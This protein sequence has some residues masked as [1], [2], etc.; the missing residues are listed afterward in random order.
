MTIALLG[1]TTPVTAGAARPKQFKEVHR[2]SR[3]TYYAPKGRSVDV[4]R[5]EAFLDRLAALFGA[6]PDGWRVQYYLHD[7]A[8][9]YSEMG[10]SAVGVT[11]LD[12]L[13]IDSVRA[14]HPHELVHAMAARLGRPP[15]LFVE[16]LAVALTSE[17]RWRG[18]GL[19][20]MAVAALGAS[21]SPRPFLDSFT[22][23][24][25]DAAYAVAGSLVAYLLDRYGIEPLV[26]FLQ[27]CGFDARRYEA[28]FKSA[29]GRTVARATLEW[30]RSLHDPSGSAREWYDPA[31]WPRSL[32]RDQAAL[33]NEPRAASVVVPAAA[34]TELQPTFIAADIP[35]TPATGSSQRLCDPSTYD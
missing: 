2:T 12:T 4:R 28:A 29:Y 27:G 25:P 23:Q 33:L 32:Q 15:I 18:G 26:A 13:R 16:G 11:N 10:R 34:A 7:E 30:E 35:P 9:V 14:Y 5:T 21:R 8:R 3:V 19:D 22:E 6:A 24:E 17:G 31:S 1:S 20:Q